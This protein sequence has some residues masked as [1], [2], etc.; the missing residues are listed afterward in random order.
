MRNA[1]LCKSAG[2]NKLLNQVHVD[3]IGNIRVHQLSFDEVVELYRSIFLARLSAKRCVLKVGC[4]RES[5]F[6]RALRGRL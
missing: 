3:A 6:V 1:R 4:M 2:R 5:D